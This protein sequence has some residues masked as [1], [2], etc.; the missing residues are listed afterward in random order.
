ME[1]YKARLVAKGYTLKEF[2]DYQEK[3]A[4]VSSNDS[5]RIIIALTAHLN[6]ELHQMDVK[7]AFLNGDIDEVIYM[8]QLEKIVVGDPKKV[9]YK[10]E[11][12]I[13]GLKQASHQWYRK[14]DQV[15]TSFGFEMN[16]IEDCV[17]H[18]IS[19][20]KFVIFL[21][22]VDDILIATNDVGMLRDTNKFLSEQFEMK[23]LGEA[24]FVLGIRIH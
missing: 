17:Y 22:H 5:L 14:F 24:S 8:Q 23:D 18:R 11:K 16:C 6:L 21:L 9:V 13:Y 2:I 12:S 7:T 20:R 10:L 15:I 4:P 3:F 1:R 19:G